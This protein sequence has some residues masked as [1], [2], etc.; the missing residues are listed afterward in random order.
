MRRS[1]WAAAVTCAAFVACGDEPHHAGGIDA[2]PAD[3]PDAALDATPPRLDGC[4]GDGT[5]GMVTVVVVAAEHAE[6]VAPPVA[7]AT[8]IASRP[9]GSMR[10]TSTTDAD[11]R[12]TI[13]IEAGDSVTVAQPM[14][15]LATRMCV[16][17]GDE[18]AFGG[19]LKLRFKDPHAGA[20][21]AETV[22]VTWPATTGMARFTVITPCGRVPVPDGD[23]PGTERG[24]ETSVQITLRASCR[25]DTIDVVVVGTPEVSGPASAG[26]LT[27]ATVTEG[28][29]LAVPALAVAA[30]LTLT[31]DVGGYA[32]LDVIGA[33]AGMPPFAFLV[34]HPPLS[35]SPGT[36]GVFYPIVTP[37]GFALKFGAYGD[38]GSEQ[39]GTRRLGANVGTFAWSATDRLPWVTDARLDA[40]GVLDLTISEGGGHDGIVM[41]A[42]TSSEGWIVTAPPTAKRIT[43]P[44]IPDTTIT[45]LREVFVYLFDLGAAPGYAELRATSEWAPL[46]A[47][48]DDLFVD[49]RASW[50][51]VRLP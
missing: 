3:A 20:P 11:G 36:P 13:P 38:G 7:G 45:E 34:E 30:P 1:T 48:F 28:A 17:P 9:D 41:I 51:I 31:T 19:E 29:V 43:L 49:H 22:T 5:P 21:P 26:S 23:D 37:A 32:T 4:D 24:D 2:G 14:G 18:L 39:D 50:N 33:E 46:A 10:G 15:R 35:L 40:S 6:P 25:A 16:K 42:R 27:G 47:H 12:A 44:V 8:V